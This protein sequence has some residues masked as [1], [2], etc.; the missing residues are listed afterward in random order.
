MPVAVITN[1]TRPEELVP[2]LA[3]YIGDNIPEIKFVSK[4]DESLIPDYPCVQ[5][6]PGDVSREYHSTHTFMVYLRALIYVMHDRL[7][8]T[9]R[10]RSEEELKL[11]T[12][13]VDLLLSDIKLG[14]RVIDGFV[15]S[16][17]PDIL[18]PRSPR[19]DI[20]VSTR[21]GWVG[22]NEVRFK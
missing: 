6:Q 17:V 7:T 2:Y 11:A 18:P 5:I 19:G 8:Q 1:I 16:E 4:Y 10:V 3:D 15:D 22:K 9:K 20:V 12:K 13:V 14:G 21:I